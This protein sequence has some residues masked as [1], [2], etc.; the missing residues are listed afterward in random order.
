M[1]RRRIDRTGT[2]S[3]PDQRDDLHRVAAV[4]N[5]I[6]PD[7]VKGLT[8]TAGRRTLLAVTGLYLLTWIAAALFL[9]GLGGLCLVSSRPR[10]AR[11]SLRA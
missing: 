4:G 6:H 8:I 5:E 9:I 3:S 7:E 10:F 1:R 11:F 2:R